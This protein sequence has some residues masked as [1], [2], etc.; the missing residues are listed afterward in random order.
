MGEYSE[1][2]E[3]PETGVLTVY[4]TVSPAPGK[5]H[6]VCALQSHKPSWRKCFP[7]MKYSPSIYY[8]LAAAHEDILSALTITVYMRHHNL[9]PQIDASVWVRGHARL[10]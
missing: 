6:D 2:G 5:E 7:E 10:G 1:M 3:I 4:I 8:L 9:L